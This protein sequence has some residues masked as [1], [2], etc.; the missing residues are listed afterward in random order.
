MSVYTH[1]PVCDDFDRPDGPLGPDRN[2]MSN[3]NFAIVGNLLTCTSTS[4][5]PF[6]ADYLAGDKRVG[7]DVTEFSL[8]SGS[9]SLKNL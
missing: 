9:S 3:P 7:L 8:S 5:A 1:E 4:F 2:F 6:G